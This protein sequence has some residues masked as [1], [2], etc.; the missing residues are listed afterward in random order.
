MTEL[1]KMV[2]QWYVDQ[3]NGKQTNIKLNKKDS[4]AIYDSIDKLVEM[5][6][7]TVDNFNTRLSTPDEIVRNKIR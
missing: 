2:Y 7:L 1:D 4:A 3:A 6:L 5:G